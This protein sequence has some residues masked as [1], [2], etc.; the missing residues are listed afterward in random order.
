MKKFTL[1]LLAALMMTAVSMA[2]KPVGHELSKSRVAAL[3][4]GQK[5]D[6]KQVPSKAS[7]QKQVDLKR[8]QSA[9]A[10]LAAKMSEAKKSEKAEK[11]TGMARAPKKV[12]T[13][14]ESYITDQPEGRKQ[15]YS[16][17]G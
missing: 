12:I 15:Y 8:L 14:D 5:A 16:R 6:A 7:L 3:A 1:F 13:G 11:A 4:P 10:L 2:Q 17:S 9:R